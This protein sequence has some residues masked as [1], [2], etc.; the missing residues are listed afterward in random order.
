MQ[1]NR[2]KLTH[3]KQPAHS[4]ATI[5]W[6]GRVEHAIPE[7]VVTTAKEYGYETTVEEVLA[8]WKKDGYLPETSVQNK[9]E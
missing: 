9:E 2:L 1:T 4:L 8:A 7:H 5:M 6:V 3:L